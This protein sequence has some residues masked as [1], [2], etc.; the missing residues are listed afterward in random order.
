M[1]FCFGIQHLNSARPNSAA[2]DA[3][4]R[5]YLQPSSGIAVKSR[6]DKELQ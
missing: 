4:L 1:A 3:T 6:N 5:R 2:T